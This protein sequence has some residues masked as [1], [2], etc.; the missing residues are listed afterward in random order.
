MA[1]AITSV[2]APRLYRTRMRLKQRKL[3]NCDMGQL[4]PVYCNLCLPGDV[5]RLKHDMV[6]RL[7]PLVAPILQEINADLHTFFV[8]I[9]LVDEDFADD[10][11]GTISGGVFRPGDPNKGA[12]GLTTKV[13]PRWIP[14]TNPPQKY[15]LWDYLG[16]PIPTSYHNFSAIGAPYPTD[17]HRRAY[18]KIYNEYFRDQRAEEEI[19]Y[20]A[21]TPATERILYRAFRKDY[22]TSA[23][24]H[25]LEGVPPSLPLSGETTADFSELDKPFYQDVILRYHEQLS[26]TTIQNPNPDGVY[27]FGTTDLQPSDP[28]LIYNNIQAQYNVSNYP[29]ISHQPVVSSTS[30]GYVNFHPQA[31]LDYRFIDWL[32]QNTVDLGTVSTFDVNQLR[33]VVQMH[34]FMERNS[35]IGLRYTEQLRGRWRISPRDDRLQR[36]E[37]VS[38]SRTPIIISEVLQ[39]SADTPTSPQ[40]N[41]AGHGLTASTNRTRKYLVKEWG[42]LITILS[43]MPKVG[44]SQGIERQY[45]YESRYD[46]PAPEFMHLGEREIL[47]TELYTTHNEAAN[48]AI[49]GFRPIY[50]EH[51][52]LHDQVCGDMR[53]TFDYWHLSRQFDAPP[54]Y[55]KE[56]I[57]TENNIRKDIFA[58]QNEPGFIVHVGTRANMVRSLPVTGDPGLI[59]HF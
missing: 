36:P 54:T 51:R 2:G 46:F 48:R 35:R 30:S 7:Q 10:E 9:R 45:L 22:F 37:Y 24:P 20:E 40:G 49:F 29:L 38:G 34:K 4:I 47:T 13:F 15:S 19:D 39:T 57:T 52:L 50:D 16:H 17:W 56:F 6:I 1:G 43:I 53:D 11:D 27:G 59:D 21:I 25:V 26:S 58:V 8:P 32:N 23:S 31:R 18:Y 33:D 3:L 55:N 5:V 14:A 44:Y 28:G 42:Y 41:L 12:D